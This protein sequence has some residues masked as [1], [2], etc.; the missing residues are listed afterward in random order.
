MATLAEVRAQYPQYSD[1]SDTALADALYKKFYSDLPRADFDVK[2]GLKTGPVKTGADLIPGQSVQAPPAQII[3]PR[4]GQ[5]GM[6]G[7]TLGGLIETP[8]AVGASLLS[9]PVTYLSGALGPEAQRKVAGA[10]Q[11]EPRTQMAQQTLE[12][13]GQAAEAA[14]LP[15]YMPASNLARTVPSAAR[16][17]GRALG[18]EGALVRESVA[19]PLAA[20]AERVQQQRIRESQINA[21]RIDAAKDALELGIAL[22][23]AVSNPTKG[24]IL[25]SRVVGTGNL[26]AKLAEQ[27]LPKYTSAAKRDMGLPDTVKLDANG[28]EQARSAPEI[29][30][31]YETVRGM[32]SL[33][34]DDATYTQLDALRVTPLVGD[35]G[36]AAAANALLDAVKQQLSAGVD[37]RTLVDS[38][39]QRRREAQAIYNQQ[40]KGVNP[41]SPESLAKADMNMGVANVLEGMIE[42][43]ITNNPTLLG[44]FRN[45]RAAMAKTYDYER[46][47]NFATGNIDP[48]IIAKMAEEGKPMSGLLAKI[49]NVAANF[50]E[51]SRANVTGK[52]QWGEKITRSSP[53]GTVGALA[54][55]PFG[56]L[57]SIAG[58]VV[59]AV[60]GNI[61]TAAEARRMATPGYQAKYAVPKDYRPPVNNLRPA[62]INYGPNQLVP[63]DFAQSVL[64]P[65]QAPYQP[66]FVFGRGTP[67]VRTGMPETA[68]LLG[69]PSPEGTINALRAEDVRR[70][71]VSRALGQEAEARAAAAEAAA[72]RPATREVILDFDPVTGR[73]R[74]ASQGLKGATP[75][76]FQR[77]SSLDAAA[78]KVTAGKPF[79]MTAAERVA[80]NKA[81]VDIKELGAGFNK[82]DDKAIAQKMMDRQ[83]VEGAIAKARQ[84]EQ[85]F[86]DIAARAQNERMRQ[87]ALAKR[88]QMM[89]LLDTLEAQYA[90]PRPTSG[91]GQGPKT[92]AAIRNQLVGGEKKNNLAP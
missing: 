67:D 34:P 62:E 65:E 21:P 81:T 30:K 88:E 90:K 51:V 10:I 92:R 49:G 50:P 44:D 37:G 29:S 87:E 33:A 84:Q 55:A 9:G 64:T 69:A 63:Y 7:E 28:F 45:A 56:L 15:P 11:Y 86:A 22:D 41:P 73:Y 83:W 19:A 46:A 40:S 38:I 79:D 20:R 75:E 27:N 16:T 66:N 52:T 68:P 18:E 25:K 89:D 13:I 74:E 17:V 72:R 80:W 8:I 58:G 70:A 14:K 91:G 82:L 23:P 24:N 4:K 59:G 42:N 57:G 71:G 53:G 76:T 35:T 3:G 31:P 2:I 6:L 5:G 12:A 39:R 36:Q 32:K 48:Q 77:L 61:L 26:D 43:N 1:M 78:E 47:T 60:G 54:G 85:A